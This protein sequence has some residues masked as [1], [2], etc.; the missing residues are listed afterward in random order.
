MK[1]QLNLIPLIITGLIII[2]FTQ[3]SNKLYRSGM[4]FYEAGQYKD[5]IEQYNQ[6]LSEDADNPKAYIARAKAYKKLNN[7]KDAADDYS[8]TAALKNDEDR[9]LKA[10]DLYFEIENYE[11]AAEMAK[12]AIK[13]DE[14]NLQAHKNA[15]KSYIE[16]QE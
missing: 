5:A 16:L 7:K 8:R 12:K 13:E 9:F 3:C 14:K 6:W 4:D 11:R 2:F 15:I 1:R 10:S